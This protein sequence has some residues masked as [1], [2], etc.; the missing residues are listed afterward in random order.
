[1]HSPRSKH[2]LLA[3]GDAL[4]IAGTAVGLAVSV[5]LLAGSAAF[6]SGGSP[7]PPQAGL[8]S[9]RHAAPR[10]MRGSSGDAGQASAQ[11]AALGSAVLLVLAAARPLVQR[12]PKRN[13]I[14]CQVSLQA[15]AFSSPQTVSMES[16]PQTIAEE[17]PPTQVIDLIDLS[18]SSVYVAP[19]PLSPAPTR[20]CCKES[21]AAPFVQGG[22]AAAS[23]PCARRPRS[24]RRAGSARRQSRQ[25][26]SRATRHAAAAAAHAEH[27][28]VGARLQRAPRVQWQEFA[29]RYDSSLKRSALQLGLRTDTT[30]P[31]ITGMEAKIPQLKA[32]SLWTGVIVND[33]RGNTFLEKPSTHSREKAL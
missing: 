23:V 29:L 30:N 20:P 10:P 33:I 19:A 5:S 11:R 6:V 17:E 15:A 22:F 31:A 21:D 12:K 2:R 14:A 26:R 16:T 24:A 27:R 18:P 9:L 8:N 1:M 28:H 32:A 7:A 13:T 25:S 3:K 4:A